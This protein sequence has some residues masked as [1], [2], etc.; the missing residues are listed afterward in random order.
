MAKL[1]SEDVTKLALS[2]VIC[3]VPGFLGSMVTAR[4]I[5]EWYAFIEKPDFT[6]PSWVFGPVWTALYVS[7]GVSLFLIWRRGTAAKSSKL[8]LTVFFIQLVLNGLWSPAF[9]GLRSP[10]LGL[11]VIVALLAAILLTVVLFYRISRRAGFL[12][13]PYLAWVG[14]AVVLNLS[15]FLLNRP[16]T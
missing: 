10:G 9:F 12:L 1:H 2:V 14:F 15:I 11:I 7:V 16:G 3:L 6:P 13:L 4:A 5:P 8:A